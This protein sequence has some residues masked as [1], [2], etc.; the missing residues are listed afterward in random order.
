MNLKYLFLCTMTLLMLAC[1]K[2]LDK[3]PDDSLILPTTLGDYNSIL[4]DNAKFQNLY[5][6]TGDMGGDEYYIDSSYFLTLSSENRAIHTWASD[7]EQVTI[8]SDWRKVYATIYGSNIVLDGL[9]K[10]EATTPADMQ[11]KANLIG[12]AL[13]IRA[14]GFYCM[15]E[16]YGQP[17]KM[18]TNAIDLGIPLRLST[19]LT[20]KSTRATVKEVFEQIL[21]DLKQ[22]AQNLPVSTL[23][24]NYPTKAA[25]YG[26]LARVCLTM[27]DYAQAGKYADSSLQ[28]KSS[29][30]DYNTLSTTSTSPF[31]ASAPDFP[32]V[33][34][35]SSLGTTTLFS[36][37]NSNQRI[38]SVLLN[39][40]VANDLRKT[41][42]FR[43]NT[44]SNTYYFKAK[45]VSYNF[46]NGPCIDE[47]YLIR[48]ECNARAGN[49]TAAMKDL[50]DLLKTRW[51]KNTNGT[52]TYVDLIASSANDALVKVIS[53][54]R[55]ELCFRGLRWIDLRRLNQ[56]PQF[57]VTLKRV[58]S[59]VT[60]TLAPN[61]PKYALP[62]PQTEIDYS[63]IP[64][65]KR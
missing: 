2:Y 12:R 17:Y 36:S 53:E 8:T 33:L 13:F 41:L 23:Y 18:T 9:K 49:T 38:D 51:K 25:A 54:R 10:I 61:D 32:E 7:I 11:L 47:M 27:Q 60:Y 21:I 46:S 55:K 31:T 40:Y 64:Q 39:S 22:S 19:D 57:A 5:P 14:F 50:N 34:Y 59:G 35:S 42:F 44:T 15:E 3:K 43:L 63:G 65:N 6:A 62:I 20:A 56:D 48:A 16:G 30:V 29:L 26:L 24:L 58:L 4:E 45:Y 37:G 28:L 52:T 1:Q